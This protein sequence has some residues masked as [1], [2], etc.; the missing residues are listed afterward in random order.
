MPGSSDPTLVKCL[1]K[2]TRF[3][4]RLVGKKD[5][6]LLLMPFRR[7]MSTL[8]KSY[9][10]KVL[11]VSLNYGGCLVDGGADSGLCD[12]SLIPLGEKTKKPGLA[13]IY[14]T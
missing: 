10:N 9:C 2:H 8:E 4:S 3:T 5:R 13:V 7:I 1:C 14:I 12:P 11:K 6:C